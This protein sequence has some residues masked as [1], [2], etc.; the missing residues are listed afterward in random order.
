MLNMFYFRIVL[1]FLV[2]GYVDAEI[3]LQ[4]LK[5]IRA[6]CVV[7][8]IDDM[9]V[10]DIVEHV[11]GKHPSKHVDTLKMMINSAKKTMMVLSKFLLF[12]KS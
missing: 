3:H 11:L 12:A 5:W 9:V 1:R 4:R 6:G 2:L 10:L 7:P 8:L